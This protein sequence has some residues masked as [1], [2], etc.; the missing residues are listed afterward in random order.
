MTSIS[1]GT[2]HPMFSCKEVTES[3]PRRYNNPDH[4]L[5]DA[6][7]KLRDSVLHS[8]S[9]TFQEITSRMHNLAERTMRA[10]AYSLRSPRFSVLRLHQRLGLRQHVFRRNKRVSFWWAACSKCTMLSDAH[11]PG[12][13]CA[14]DS[15]ARLS[16]SAMSNVSFLIPR[17]HPTLSAPY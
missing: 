5:P 4:L 14:V 6:H 3:I 11:F 15:G 1:K 8:S 10:K 13:T 9:W 16:S 2:L 17:Q 12:G 7:P